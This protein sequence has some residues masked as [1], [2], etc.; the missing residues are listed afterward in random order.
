MDK[1]ARYLSYYE[2][3]NKGDSILGVA[4]LYDKLSEKFY[5]LSPRNT[6]LDGDNTVEI[7]S[8]SLL[9]RYD[10]EQEKMVYDVKGLNYFA[11]SKDLVVDDDLFYLSNKLGTNKMIV[12]MDILKGAIDNA[13]SLFYTYIKQNIYTDEFTIL[14]TFIDLKN[15]KSFKVNNNI[16]NKLIDENITYFVQDIKDMSKMYSIIFNG[17]TSKEDNRKKWQF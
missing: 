3:S 10:N 7:V 12:P 9:Y 11:N 4:F 17:Y 5:Y 13:D 6:L 15:D 1:I 16:I 8:D 14:D 2:E